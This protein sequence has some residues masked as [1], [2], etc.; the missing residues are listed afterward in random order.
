MPDEGGGVQIRLSQDG[1]AE[2]VSTLQQILTKLDELGAASKTSAGKTD[3]ITESLKKVSES[4]ADT[5]FATAATAAMQ[6]GMQVYEAGEKIYHYVAAMIEMKAEHEQELIRL[7]GLNEKMLGWVGATAQA[8]ANMG[9][10]IRM[11]A[12]A[13]LGSLVTVFQRLTLMVGGTDASIMNLTQRM[14]LFGQKAGVTA[15]QLLRVIQMAERT[16]TLPMRGQMAVA[17]MAMQDAGITGADIK[18]AAMSGTLD[19]LLQKLQLSTEATAALENS[20]ANLTSGLKRAKDEAIESVAS[21]LDGLKTSVKELTTAL[22]STESQQG[23]ESLGRNLALLVN[24]L[25]SLSSSDAGAQGFVSY[26]TT[27][28]NILVAVFSSITS[29]VKLFFDTVSAITVALWE[30]VTHP[31]KSLSDLDELKRFLNAEVDAFKEA[32]GKIKATW[33]TAVGGPAPWADIKNYEN[34]YDASGKLPAGYHSPVK[35]DV[36]LQTDAAVEALQALYDKMDEKHDLAGLTG[37]ARKMQEI[38]NAADQADVAMTK[39]YNTAIDKGWHPTATQ[40]A[41]FD[42]KQAQLQIDA[43]AE[44]EKTLRDEFDKSQKHYEDEQ[45]RSFK[46]RE[47]AENQYDQTLVALTKK[48]SDDILEQ[49]RASTDAQIENMAIKV[50]KQIEAIDAAIKA[51][52][53]AGYEDDSGPFKDAIEKKKAFQEGFDKWAEAQRTMEAE[54][55]KAITDLQNGNWTAYYDDLMKK[56]ANAHQ[57]MFVAAQENQKKTADEME[58]AAQ[59]GADG[60]TAGLAKIRTTIGSFGQDVATLMTSVWASL[61]T[62]FDSGFYDILTGKFS[63]LGNVL[64]SLWDSILKDFSKM[65][66]QMLERWLVTGDAMGN[67]QG[68]GG[69]FGGLSSMFGGGGTGNAAAGWQ[70]GGT[71]FVGPTQYGAGTY[72]QGG[73]YESGSGNQGG[74]MGILGYAAAAYMLYNA[75]ATSFAKPTT[76]TPTYQG[77]DLGQTANFGGASG[78]LTSWL[79]AAAMVAVAGGFNPVSIVAAVVIAIVGVIVSIFNGPQEGHVAIAISD[80]FGKT[81]ATSVIGGFVAQ[82]IDSTSTFVGQLALKAAGP[83]G[84]AGYVASYQKAFQT[85]Y[86]NAKFDLAAGSPADLQKDVQAFFDT[87]LPKLAMQAAFGQVGYGPNGNRDATGGVAGLD[88]NTNNGLMGQSGNWTDKKLYDSAAAIPQILA[89]LGFIPDEINVIAQ[90]LADATDMKVFKQWLSD[91][92]GVVVDLSDLAQ[93]F[94][95][96]RDDWFAFIHKTQAEVGTAAEFADATAHFK[97]GGELLATIFGDDRVAAAKTLVT[98]GQ[99]LLNNEA[100][101]LA[102]IL[103]FID[104]IATTTASTIQKY[105]SGQ[106]TPAENEAALRTDATAGYKAIGD[107]MNPKD[108][109]A[110]WQRVLGDMTALLDIIAARIA[111]IK[112]LQQSYADFRTQMATDAGPQFATDPT[113]WLTDNQSKIDAITTTLKT[114]TGDDAIAQAKT[115]LGLVQDRYNNEIQMLQRVKAAIEQVDT[116]VSAAV[117]TLSLQALG[118]VTTDA[119]GNKTWTPDTHAQGDAMWAQVSTLE[120][121]LATAA[122][123]E[124]A[125]RIWGQISG[126]LNQLAAQPQDPE[127]YAESRKILEKAWTDAGKIFDDQML[128]VQHTIETDLTGIGD[129][130]KAGET[131]LAKALKDAQWDFGQ[132]LHNLGLASDE[133]TLKLNGFADALVTQM[134]LLTTAINGWIALF[135]GQTNPAGGTTV[136]LPGGGI[137]T[138]G[139]WETDPDDPT[140]QRKANKNGGYTYRPMPHPTGDTNPAPSA[141]SSRATV[142]GTSSVAALQS[143]V[144]AVNEATAALN[145]GATS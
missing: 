16:G 31:W 82:I 50:G 11:S 119:S 4:G 135:T 3:E 46:Q 5:A 39:A 62:A 38:Q 136:P 74:G 133:A 85:A 94:G 64:K 95:Q 32:A 92:V 59:T 12:N 36:K 30:V 22:N 47:A 70:E 120:G 141:A 83:E 26:W 142:P 140:Q 53:L 63:D 115:L 121:Q 144:R 137:D 33:T 131:A 19:Q 130:L 56:A 24:Q 75:A 124:A 98:E 103:T 109:A 72:Y 126:L 138:T 122:T 105:Q 100:T 54:K 90:K 116:E 125:T 91:L 143:F 84:V 111:N 55:E 102:N 110:A 78:Q 71:D 7:T 13:D 41:E 6:F 69:A 114:A 25:K 66:T 77:Q 76:S 20:W 51:A 14:E 145:G 104:Q 101:A 35:P 2:V 81:G 10:L 65:L 117:N 68:T 89:K 139:G 45:A 127:H 9:N 86:G 112:A 42:T 61:T 129:Q 1:G 8:E 29:L 123:P 134:G 15:E 40:S 27:V 67:G 58:K 93:K 97:A 87:V 128:K 23:F 106:M 21:G 43:N 96:S 107:A 28:G 52:P 57:N 73:G 99:T 118:S 132:A 60:W 44:K 113:A 17:S 49:M 108:V 37:I 80:A 88:W 18:A 48:T 79:S 34:E